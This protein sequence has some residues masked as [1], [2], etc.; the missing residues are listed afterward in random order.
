MIIDIESA[1]SAH[2]LM[3]LDKYN[4]GRISENKFRQHNMT[5]IL[6]QEQ[7]EIKEGTL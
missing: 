4:Q 5:L 3:L 6:W 2:Y 1:Y 7:L